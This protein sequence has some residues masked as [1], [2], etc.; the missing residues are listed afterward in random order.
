MALYGPAEDRDNPPGDLSIIRA[1]TVTLVLPGGDRVTAAIGVTS[2]GVLVEPLIA[3][4]VDDEDQVVFLA[5]VLAAAELEL[6]L[7]PSALVA[8]VLQ[9][10]PAPLPQTE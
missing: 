4:S 9:E 8:V 5:L 2:D 7:D 10:S 1:T 6:G 3:G